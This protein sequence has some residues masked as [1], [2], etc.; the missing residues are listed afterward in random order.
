MSLK[1]FLKSKTFVFHIALI[2]IVMGV[3]VYLAMLFISVYTHHG[4]TMPV[5]DL[6]GLTEK[7]V[8]YEIEAQKLRY[9]IVDSIFIAEAAPGTIIAQQPKANY[10]VKARRTIYLTIAAISP[11]QVVLPE[12]VNWSIREAQ[13]RLENA[14]LRLGKVEYIPSEFNKLVLDKKLNGRVLPDDTLLVKGTAV[15]L[16]VGQG[17]SNEVTEVP[18]L[19]GADIE[20]AKEML[21][22][23]GLNVGAVIY[24]NSFET[25]EDSINALVYRQ[26]PQSNKNETTEL[27]KSVD[28]WITIDQEKIDNLKDNEF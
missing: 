10:K 26:N 4:K 5:P 12:I 15:D 17:L 3:L 20:S 6:I 21:Y 18:D 8:Q 19:L 7:E 11:E 14:G 22:N 16:V 2:L 13:S 23:V 27:G 9:R 1:A 28:L 25:A 24:D